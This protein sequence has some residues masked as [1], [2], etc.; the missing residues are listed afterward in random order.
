[1]ISTSS[2]PIAF[3]LRRDPLAQPQVTAV[4]AVGQ[5]EGV[6]IDPEV[7][8]GRVCDGTL[9]EV[10]VDRRIAALL[11]R[12]LFDG[13]ASVFHEIS[14]SRAMPWGAGPLGHDELNAHPAGRTLNREPWLTSGPGAVAHRIIEITSCNAI[15]LLIPCVD[16]R[17]DDTDQATAE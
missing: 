3:V 4:L 6:Q 5:S 11:R 10:E 9:G 13:H 12:L 17:G 1:V 14:R 8:K 2:G 16:G 7:A 15:R